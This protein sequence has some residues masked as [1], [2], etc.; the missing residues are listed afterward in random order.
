MEIL[1]AILPY[2]SADFYR[3]LGAVDHVAASVH[4]DIMDGRFVP[5]K[6]W[7][8]PDAI[9]DATA[10][11]LELH[12]M[13][14]DALAGVKTWGSIPQ[15]T[16]VAVHIESDHVARA[17]KQLHNWKK[18]VYI[19]LNPE[20]PLTAIIPSLDHIDGVLFMTVHPGK[21]GNPFQASVL[22]KMQSFHANYPDCPIA[23]DGHVDETTLPALIAAGAASL[24]VGSAIMKSENPETQ[25][26]KLE[27]LAASLTQEK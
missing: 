21:Q 25:L 7:S 1:P 15:V 2:T 9:Q 27:S 12:L 10:I 23:V 3:D 16:R 13:V 20:T 14:Q 5:G 18:E 26:K 22:K 24:C 8:D 11:P 6:T 19:A 17:I 4:L